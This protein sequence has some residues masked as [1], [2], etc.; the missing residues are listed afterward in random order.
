[1]LISQLY[2][3]IYDFALA[4]VT[5][6]PEGRI[7]FA[8]Q[9]SPRPKKPFI[10]IS[11]ANFKNVG[12]P[13]IR[14]TDTSGGQEIMTSMVM[15]ASFIAF[16]DTLHE[17]EDLLGLLY[18]AFNTE[19]QNSIFKGKIALHRVLKNITALPVMLNEQMES[20]AILEL[21][22]AFNK[23]TEDN[24]GIIEKVQIKN[25]VN[26]TEFIIPKEI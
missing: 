20:R 5:V 3:N 6:L 18:N 21:E 13:I 1:M 19:L 22:I 16:S 2:S 11:L 15:T 14:V 24:V 25:M 26:N 10:T 9:S 4:A 8:N 12:T 17:A 7:I 23:T